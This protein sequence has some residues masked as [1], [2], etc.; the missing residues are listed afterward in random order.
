V[1]RKKGRKKEEKEALRH[2]VWVQISL[3]NQRKNIEQEARRSEEGRMPA[4]ENEPF[5]PLTSSHL[6]VSAPPV[7][8]SSR[9][10]KPQVLRKD[11]HETPQ[12]LKNSENAIEQEQRRNGGRKGSGR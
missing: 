2:F 9:F 12:D 6:S 10:D 7:R 8:F 1:R 5:P 11:P 4:G 3:D